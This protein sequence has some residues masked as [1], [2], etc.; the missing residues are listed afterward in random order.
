V[1]ASTEYCVTGL[2]FLEG[3]TAGRM[4]ALLFFLGLALAFEFV[5]GFHDTANAVA[6]VIYTK[7]LRPRT[8]V[9][10]SGICNFLGVHLGG[11][12]VA[13]SIV[14]LL[15]VELLVSIGSGTGMAMVLA[16]LS[17]AIL[18]NLGTWYLALPASSS[19]TLIGA[20]LGIGLSNALLQGR[21]LSSG[22]N[23][24][25]AFEVIASLL[26]SPLIGFVL[27]ALVYVLIKKLARDP[28]LEEA[29][30]GDQPPPPWIRA[31][32]VGTCS[33][34][35]VAHGSNDGQKGVGLIMLILIGLLPARYAIDPEFGP[36]QV[37]QALLAA[38]R[39]EGLLDRQPTAGDERN[40][41]VRGLL[42]DLR[43]TL[44]RVPHATLLDA[45]ERWQ[46]RS[47]LLR[48][49]RSL[50]DLALLFEPGPLST[51]DER[52]IVACRTELRKAT[53]FAPTWVTVAVACA[54][55]CGT[56]IG[57]ER[58]V[59]TVGEKIGKSHLTYL[60]GASAE[61]V[62]ACTIGIAD[63]GGM[64]VSTTHVLSSGVAGTMAMAR[65]GLQ[66]QTLSRI[67]IAWVLTMPAAMALS[68]TFFLV[69]SRWMA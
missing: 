24:A 38:S 46:V 64:P 62:A 50:Q 9:L 43:Q 69:F 63:L 52:L 61:V 8:A 13:F 49:D 11:T 36:P 35:S 16:L 68:G 19:H 29:P 51:A 2:S 14:H 12:A 45:H 34:V 21:P 58:I 33:A 27:A 44:E 17:A 15:P 67:G 26:I 37:A 10:L 1:S 31:V 59:V 22:V 42:D 32:L 4:L 39:L 54:L 30:A 56:M 40:V 66:Y 3:A 28:R 6:T 55:G 47:D 7:T 48:I 60:Q 23:W 5:N 18:W 53:D 20:I 57:W 25:K 65:A 41:R